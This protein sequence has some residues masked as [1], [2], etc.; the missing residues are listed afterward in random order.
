MFRPFFAVFTVAC[1]VFV[2]L[3]SAEEQT[4]AEKERQRLRERIVRYLLDHGQQR[5]TVGIGHVAGWQ[6]GRGIQNQRLGTQHP[7]SELRRRL[8]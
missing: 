4:A 1:L 3:V 2:H 7:A 5:V 6:T 8:V